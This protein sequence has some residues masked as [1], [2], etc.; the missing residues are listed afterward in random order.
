M[1]LNCKFLT[2]TK[3]NPADFR[4]FAFFDVF[5]IQGKWKAPTVFFILMALF[6]SVCFVMHEKRG[7]VFLG[8]VLLTVGLLLP[9][10]YCLSFLL[11][12]NRQCRRI[13]P[14]Q[15][16]YTLRFFEDRFE[17]LKGKETAAFRWDELYHAYRRAHGIYLYVQPR[18]AFIVSE[19]ETADE[20]WAF[21][22][23]QLRS[24]Q[25][26]DRR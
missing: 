9:I 17:V 4:E 14:G 13:A 6:S 16:V 19:E 1:S 5:R 21:L 26:T 10:C 11:S 15:T 25:I 24:G 7:A 22:R 18:H 12:V 20:L 23:S 8:C 2:E 3:L